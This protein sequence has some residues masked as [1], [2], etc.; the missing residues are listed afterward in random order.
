MVLIVRKGRIK[1]KIAAMQ[2]ETVPECSSLEVA[3][4]GPL[5]WRLQNWGR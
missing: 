4:L 1:E 2:K 3:K 5:I